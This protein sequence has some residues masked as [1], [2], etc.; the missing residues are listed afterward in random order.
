[1]IAVVYGTRPEA[2]KL[3]PVV[4]AMRC[5]QLPVR[6]VCTGQHE[7]LLDGAADLEP[8][9]GLG[10]MHARQQ[11]G[12]FLPR[13]IE[14]LYRLWSPP[15]SRPARVVVQ[16]DTA[17]AFA[18]ALAAFHLQVP[19]AHVEAGLRSHDLT[20]PFPEEGYRQMISRIADRHYAPTQRALENLLGEGIGMR[21]TTSIL[22]TGNTG[23]DAAMRVGSRKSPFDPP[24]VLVTLHR[25]EAFGE[26]MRA[27]CRAI[28]KLAGT[29]RAGAAPLSFVVPMHPNPAA[30][31]VIE[32]ELAGS[33][34]VS[35][36]EPMPHEDLITVLRSAW[37]VL[38]DSGGIQEEAPA[39]GVPVLVARETTERPE[40]IEAGAA[41]VVG[42][43]EKVIVQTIL[44][45]RESP[46][47]YE[48]MWL[49][50][51]IYG[52]GQAAERI[53]ADLSSST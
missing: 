3:A 28:R 21:R 15:I 2:I 36:I 10:L 29:T 38:T 33:A 16:G 41:L 32:E 43:D 11:P 47:E 51:M 37:C 9:D 4:E 18:A 13:C 22:V 35:L 5:R 20:A 19:V 30:R 17:T 48:A 49:P 52:D 40:G 8:D 42:Y 27:V 50:R 45:M 26:P 24:Y 6:V 31:A 12:D 53:A 14:A 39:F 46:R 44:G 25:R 7:S 23:I 1:M 34:H